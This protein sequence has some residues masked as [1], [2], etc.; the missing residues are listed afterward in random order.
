MIT[1]AGLTRRRTSRGFTLVELLLAVVL[2]LM[3]IG[4][5]AFNFSTLQRGAE[6]EEG[7]AQFESL[8]RF[9]RA[10]AANSGRQIQLRFGAPGGDGRSQ[11]VTSMRVVWEPDPLGQ[12]GNFVDLPE[13]DTYL[14]AITDLVQAG[15][16]PQE[17]RVSGRAGPI[18]ESKNEN[19]SEMTV[20]MPITFYPDGSSDSA[21]IILKSRD[22]DDQRL[23]SVR[24]SGVTGSIRRRII[25]LDSQLNEPEEPEPEEIGPEPGENALTEKTQ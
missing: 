25:T 10:S 4:A 15:P 23:M 8:L 21:E 7:A 2:L 22:V 9:V 16:K 5:L 1:Q 12:P 6:L 20:E 19:P 11:P 13:A 24:L 14:R 3:L 18:T 17:N